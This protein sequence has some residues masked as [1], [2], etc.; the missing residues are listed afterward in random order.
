MKNLIQY[1]SNKNVVYSCKYHVVWCPKY[2][3]KV[4]IDGVDE[5]LKVIL[6][7][8][9]EKLDSE[10]I[11]MEIMEDHVHL[12]V[13][14]DPQFGINKLIKKMK[15]TSSRLLRE[16]FPWLKSRIPSLWTN[17]Y[18]VSTVGGATLDTVKLYIENQKNV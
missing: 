16:E 13:D 7:E 8:V 6:Q 3:R 2:R 12:L 9:A 5:R 1:K 10:I 14:V 11:E 15:G 4:L 17:S 18:F